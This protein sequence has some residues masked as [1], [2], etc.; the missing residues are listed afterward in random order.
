[1]L[2]LKFATH[3]WILKCT[4]SLHIKGNFS[5]RSTTLQRHVNGFNLPDHA[6]L[7]QNV[8]DPYPFL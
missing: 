7:Q 4:Y 5:H 2:F 3:H 8:F 6:T 1:M